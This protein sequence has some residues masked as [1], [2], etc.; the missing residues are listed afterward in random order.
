MK[1]TFIL[2]KEII[3]NPFE[4]YKKLGDDTKLFLPF[5]VIILLFLLYL[6][7]MIPLQTSEAY[8]NAVA[9]IQMAAIAERTAEPSDAQK[10]AI[11]EQMNSPM[12]RNITIASSL[13]GGLISYIVITLVT[14]LLLKLIAGGFKRES[15]RYSLVLKVILF[16]SIVSVAQAIVK[17]G[18]TVSGDWQRALAR[19]NTAADLQTA[20][21]SPVS[22]AAFFDASTMNRQIFT[23]VDFLTDIFNWVYFLFIYAGIRS[24]MVLEKKKALAATII[25]ALISIVMALAFTLIG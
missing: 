13:G 6:T 14:A 9:R 1:N 21:Q 20:L 4:G 8:G 23:L 22:L 7:M 3:A 25:L 12:M 18:I 10:E 5:L 11:L 19:V 17:M 16:A 24:A 2:W 15:V